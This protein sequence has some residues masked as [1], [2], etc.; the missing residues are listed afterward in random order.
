M[1]YLGLNLHGRNASLTVCENYFEEEND[2]DGED[3][4]H[5]DVEDALGSML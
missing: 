1:T 2:C 5:L 4:D 3:A